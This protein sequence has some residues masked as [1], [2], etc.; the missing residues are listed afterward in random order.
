MKRLNGNKMVLV[1]FVAVVVLSVGSAKADIIFGGPTNL[2]TNVNSGACDDALNISSD[3]L[4][5]IFSSDRPDWGTWD[6]Y[7]STRETT[8]DDWGP[9][10]K[11]SS[12][13]NGP[14]SESYPSLSADGLELFYTAPFWQAGWTQFGGADLWVSKRSTVSDEWSAPVNLG[15]LVNTSFHDTEPSISADGLELYFSSDRPGGYGESNIWVTKRQTR[16]DPWQEP[17]NLG[18]TINSGTEGT[19][20]ISTDGLVLLFASGRSGGYGKGDIWLSRRKSK[21]DPWQEPVNIGPP[22]NDSGGQWAPCISHDGSTLYFTDSGKQP[23]YGCFDLWQ[24]DVS[25]SVDFNG[26]DY[27]DIED[28][29]ILV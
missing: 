28:L 12:T 20:N 22:V 11:L 25:P 2:G 21:E 16:N 6:L 3:G 27:I 14:R 1:G 29:L 13:L 8:E 17:V 4:S 15:E 24:V 7:M 10:V 9:S 5:I 26:D 18:P 23:K 19:P